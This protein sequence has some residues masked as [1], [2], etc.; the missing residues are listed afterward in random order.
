MATIHT[1]PDKPAETWR[2]LADQLTPQQIAELEYCEREQVP[3]GL[4]EP[5][6][7]LNSA[8]RMIEDNLRQIKNAGIAAPADAIDEPSPWEDW[9]DERDARMYVAATIPVAGTNITVNVVG[10][11]FDNGEIERSIATWYTQTPGRVGHDDESMT[12]DV[13]R[14]YAAA[15]IEAADA[16]DA[17]K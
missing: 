17:L 16:L 11:Q 15:L 3:P 7:F 1:L 14:R 6:H 8:R 12:P 2:D 5:R 9:D 4:T 13:A 10:W